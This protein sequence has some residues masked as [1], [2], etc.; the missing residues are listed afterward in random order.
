MESRRNRVVQQEG[1]IQRYGLRY[2]PVD[3]VHQPALG[4]YGQGLG[5]GS[6]Y[7][8]KDR[9]RMIQAEEIRV[10][11]AYGASTRA[12]VHNSRV[13]RYGVPLHDLSYWLTNLRPD[14][15]VSS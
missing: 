9:E 14:A 1:E 5:A 11:P 8:D 7:L 3:G 4:C 6:G 12:M 13:T 10:S 2:G 15:S